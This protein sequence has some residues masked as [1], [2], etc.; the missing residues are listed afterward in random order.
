ML[1]QI[2]QKKFVILAFYH[3]VD[4]LF[5]TQKPTLKILGVSFGKLVS[6]HPSYLV[7]TSIRGLGAILCDIQFQNDM[8]IHT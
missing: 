1:W 4:L 5:L 7:Y 6:P 8:L 3:L 2:M